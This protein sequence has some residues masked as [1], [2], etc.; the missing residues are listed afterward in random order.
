MTYSDPDDGYRSYAEQTATSC[1]AR[2]DAPEVGMGD[3]YCTLETGHEG[4]HSWA[5]LA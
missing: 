1:D 4:E 5:G 3:Q 2:L